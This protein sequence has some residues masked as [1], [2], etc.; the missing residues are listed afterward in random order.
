MP[1][2]PAKMGA[3]N[4]SIFVVPLSVASLTSSRT[5]NATEFDCIGAAL[6]N[7]CRYTQLKFIAEFSLKVLCS[8]HTLLVALY[9]R[10]RRPFVSSAQQWGPT[11]ITVSYKRGERERDNDEDGGITFCYT[12]RL[13][14]VVKPP[15]NAVCFIFMPKTYNFNQT[16]FIRRN[17]CMYSLVCIVSNWQHRRPYPGYSVS[18]IRNITHFN[19]GL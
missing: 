16:P 17:M 8:L 10:S 5:H 11:P 18:H 9:R 4:G 1:F 2:P 7:T 12:F 13:L 6:A 15:H 14:F 3:G 19:W